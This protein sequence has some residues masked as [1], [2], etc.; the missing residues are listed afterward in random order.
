MAGALLAVE[1]VLA[2]LI[3]RERTG[4][5][6]IHDVALSDAALVGAAARLGPDHA[7]DR[8]R[9][10]LLL[11]RAGLAAHA[12]KRLVQLSG[13]Q[14]QRVAMVRALMNRPRLVLAD[15]PTGNLDSRTAPE[16]FALRRE[17]NRDAGT[18]FLIVTHDAGLAT[19]CDRQVSLQDGR[20]VRDS[21][22]AA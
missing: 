5:G 7:G 13:G 9:A 12:H 16:V 17:L 19:R 3:S 20:L 11:E 14:Q 18:A 8:R 15:E 1:A 10:R 6:G 22:G 21:A 4:H 2:A